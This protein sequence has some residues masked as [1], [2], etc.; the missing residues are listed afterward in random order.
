MIRQVISELILL[1]LRN[2]TV[3]KFNSENAIVEDQ[4]VGTIEINQNSENPVTG[5]LW[6]S[7]EKREKH[8]SD[9]NNLDKNN[10]KLFLI[11]LES[12]HIEE[13]KSISIPP[14]PALGKTGLNLQNNLIEKIRDFVNNNSGK[15]PNGKYKVILSNAIQYQA[16]LGYDTEIFRDRCWL[17]M[18][19][20]GGRDNFIERIKKYKPDV[21]INACTEGSHKYD[22]F[23]KS[24]GNIRIDYLRNVDNAVN[25]DPASFTLTYKKDEIYDGKY[26][27]N[28]PKK[29]E[30]KNYLLRG[31]VM[32]AIEQA[33]QTESQPTVYLHSVHPSSKHFTKKQN[34]TWE[35][36][37]RE[38]FY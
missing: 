26:L 2:K 29:R 34:N 36:P 19:L 33:F 9:L 25:Q 11:I 6:C 31:F 18:W 21:I 35:N 13:F 3:V 7:K 10:E 4:Y 32:T 30:L 23:F 17:M 5:N 22:P 12:P 15:I 37:I 24:N 14:S 8:S 16:S 1:N 38:D 27:K 20:S 28:T